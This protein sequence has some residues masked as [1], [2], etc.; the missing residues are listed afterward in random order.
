VLL[1]FLF[2][3]EELAR[4]FKRLGYGFTPDTVRK[5]V[6]YYDRR[7]SHGST[8][9]FIAHAGVLAD[10]DPESSWERYMVALESD[11]GDVQ[12]GTT[13]EG[14]HMGVM[15][16]T[17]DLIQRAYLGTEV[18]DDVLRFDPKP[19]GNLDGLTFPMRFRR[20][21]IEVSL[22]GR[23]LTVAV[24]DDGLGCP[25]KVGVGDEELEIRAGENY[26]VGT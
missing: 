18:R 14:I 23:K 3:E 25:I 1:F 11:V 16:G 20:T 26:T 19:V 21:P 6:A 7:T 15:A 4:I 17:L 22:E 24:Q 10:L 2:P 12:G 5:N 13:K 9:S 8:L